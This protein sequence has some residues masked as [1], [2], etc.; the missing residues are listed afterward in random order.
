MKSNK[1]NKVLLSK[2]LIFLKPYIKKI[3]VIFLCI[4]AS[5]VIS[6][7]I[8]LFSKKIMDEGLLMHNF[9]LIVRYTIVIFV[10]VLIDQIIGLLEIKYYSYINAMFQ[11]SLNKVAFKHLLKLKVTYFNKVNFSE[12]ISNI[13][14]DVGNITRICDGGTFIIIS[15][16]FRIFGGII[17]LSLIDWKLTL[18][19]ITIVPLRYIIVRA[20]AKKR[21]GLIKEFIEFNRDFSSWYGDTICG[22]REIK[23]WGIDRIK[24]GEFIKKQR[25]IIK[26][27]IKMAFLDKLNEYSETLLFHIINSTLYILGSSIVFSN[28]TSIRGLF[29]FLTYSSY[30]IGPI[31]LILNIGYNFS[32][33][34]PSAKRYLDF[35][36][37]ETEINEQQLKPI[38][39]SNLQVKGKINFENIIFAYNDE[40]NL[41]SDISFEINCGE[42]AAIIGING[43]GKTTLINLLLRFYNSQQGKIL[44]DGIDIRQI[45]LKDYRNLISVFSQELYLFN[46]SIEHNI[47][48]YSKSD[49]LKVHK[50]AEES[51]AYE[52][53]QNMPLKY[54]TQVGSGGSNLSGGQRQNVAMARALIRDSKNINFR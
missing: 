4:F 44:L 42:K 48:L 25:K 6:I 39:T 52:F 34:V 45:K 33:I 2:I 37:I 16:V 32:N 21:K 28:G 17:G 19:V 53:I 40:V 29:A 1:E 49:Q 15:Q 11:F 31:S 47:N 51:R 14:V 5:S 38:R 7:I 36:D 13:G 10:F 26:I 23:L 12:I 22:I 18:L 8:P 35:L 30:V 27:N 9:F 3:S 41:L 50:A 43:S 54:N 24:I 20:L 46:E